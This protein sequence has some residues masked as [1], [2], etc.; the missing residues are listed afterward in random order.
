MDPDAVLQEVLRSIREISP[1]DHAVTQRGLDLFLENQ[2]VLLR[3][4]RTVL[5]QTGGKVSGIR[6]YGVRQDGVLGRLGFENGDRLDR[7]MGKSMS[8]PEQALEAYATM[9][10]AKVIEIEVYR[11]GVPTKL[12]VRVE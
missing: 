5:E 3:S 10:S 7:V 6:I 2:V 9:R 11:R 12:I 1:N 8:T 4:A